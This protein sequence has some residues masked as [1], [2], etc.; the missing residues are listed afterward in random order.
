MNTDPQQPV[1]PCA[2]LATAW[3]HVAPPP[4]APILPPAV[5]LAIPGTPPASPV[6]YTPRRPC[7]CAPKCAAAPAAAPPAEGG[8]CGCA[9]NR[10][11]WAAVVAGGVTAWWVARSCRG[12]G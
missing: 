3:A 6:Q 10:F 5:A 7:R 1:D 8:G 9:R 11:P 12:R 4:P 2:A